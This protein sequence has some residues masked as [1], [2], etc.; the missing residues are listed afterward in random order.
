M[1]Q[2][3]NNGWVPLLQEE[4]H[5]Y[6]EGKVGDPGSRDVT[7]DVVS[8]GPAAHC[9]HQ[10]THTRVQ[11][12]IQVKQFCALDCHPVGNKRNCCYRLPSTVIMSVTN[13]FFFC[14][15]LL[16]FQLIIIDKTT[17]GPTDGIYK[18]LNDK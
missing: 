10:A 7:S 16:Q 18:L 17:Q 4:Q 11:L 8:S 3:G 14:F 2:G 12:S 1:V 9:E 5:H 13:V 6:S 15:F